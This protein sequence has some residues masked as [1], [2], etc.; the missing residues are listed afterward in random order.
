M[1]K[2]MMYCCDFCLFKVD[3]SQLIDRLSFMRN[4]CFFIAVSRKEKQSL[5]QGFKQSVDD[6]KCWYI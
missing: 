1:V 2:E 6:I 3:F 4:W 5:E